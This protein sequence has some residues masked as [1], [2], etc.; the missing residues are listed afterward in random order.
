LKPRQWYSIAGL[1]WA[2]VL[3]P[4]AGSVAFAF[5]EGTAWIFVFGDERWPPAAQWGIA[6]LAAVIA[7]ALSAAAFRWLRRREA[8][9]PQDAEKVKALIFAALPFFM[10]ALAGGEMWFKIEQQKIEVTRA[11]KK[12]ADFADLAGTKHQ[13]ASID[14]AAEGAAIRAAVRLAGQR[15]G[16]YRLSWRVVPSTARLSILAESRALRLAAGEH[17]ET[18][19]FTLNDLA[20]RYREIVPNGG[21]GVLVDENFELD[22]S[23]D[24]VL[25]PQQRADLP[26]G[27]PNR[28][29]TAESALH[30]EKTAPVPVR[31]TIE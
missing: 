9:E 20:K 22:V 26:P 21:R 17:E 16:A 10:L 27:E 4:T 25:T 12:E 5:L 31:F 14:I 8:V 18:L 24:P 7:L 1:S 29:G 6:L 19:D 13:I 15:D 2:L 30:S 23:L 3:I 28:L 11:A